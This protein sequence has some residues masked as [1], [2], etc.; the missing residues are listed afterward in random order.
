MF[1]S[2]T[3]LGH[4][5]LRVPRQPAARAVPR[6]LRAAFAGANR[7]QICLAPR[8][9]AIAYLQTQRQAECLELAD[10]RLEYLELRPAQLDRK[11]AGARPR[12][13]FDRLER[14]HRPHPGCIEARKF[15]AQLTQVSVAEPR[16]V[17]EC[18][19]CIGL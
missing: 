19:P 1:D 7:A 18:L 10:V 8:R 14:G 15:L 6:S 13:G 11:V 3:P 12:A 17:R 9:E 16:V 2:R 4:S 5:G